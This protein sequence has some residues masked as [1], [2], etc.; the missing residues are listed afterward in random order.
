MGAGKMNRKQ[1]KE[2]GRRLHRRTPVWSWCIRAPQGLMWAT[3]RITWQY[4]RN[5]MQSQSVRSSASQ[6][7]CIEW[8]I[9]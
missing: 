7:T 8:R 5:K 3:A 2:L 4:A 9:G 6:R 1:R